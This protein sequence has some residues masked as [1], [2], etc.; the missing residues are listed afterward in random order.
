MFGYANFTYFPM[1][2]SLTDGEQK[3][4]REFI[5]TFAKK[6]CDSTITDVDKLPTKPAS[7]YCIKDE[8]KGELQHV[9]LQYLCDRYSLRRV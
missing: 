4:A 1:S 3:S 9:A 5:E 6:T 8:V 2:V 7:H